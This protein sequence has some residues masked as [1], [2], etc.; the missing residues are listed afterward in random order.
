MAADRERVHSS[1][2][3]LDP[4]QW[5]ALG[6]AAHPVPAPRVPGGPR[7]HR[8]HR[9]RHAAGSRAISRCAMRSGLAAAAPPSSRPT[10]MASSSST[11]PGRRPTR[12]SG[13]ATT[14]SSPSPSLHARDRPAPAGAPRARSRPRSP[15]GC[16]KR[17]SATPRRRGVSAVHALFLDEPARAACA[18]ARL[19]AAAR[20]PVPLDQPRLRELRGLPRDLHR[21]EAQEGAPRAPPRRREPA[22]ASRPASAAIS[23]GR[24]LD[25]IYALHRDTFLRHGHEPYLT[26]AFFTEVA[27]RA[28]RGARW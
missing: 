27:R 2:D 14:R 22:S 12:G 6:G 28:A 8:L 24:L 26:R 25:R 13:G 7:A 23:T 17:S 15:R 20:L 19:A 1:I 5:N 10:P 21:R 16:S 9:P 11:S 4:R 18:R 3:E